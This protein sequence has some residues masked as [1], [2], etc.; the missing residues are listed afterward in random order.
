M[1]IGSTHVDPGVV[2]RQATCCRDTGCSPMNDA[3]DGDLVT[4][5]AR[6]LAL[7]LADDPGVRYAVERGDALRLVRRRPDGLVEVDYL[8]RRWVV[9]EASL[10]LLSRLLDNVSL[11]K[12]GPPATAPPAVVAGGSGAGP[13]APSGGALATKEQTPDRTDRRIGVRWRMMFVGAAVVALVVLTL[14]LARRFNAG[15]AS[16]PSAQTAPSND[17]VPTVTVTAT[18]VAPVVPVATPAATQRPTPRATVVP[19]VVSNL[20]V[21]DSTVDCGIA[22]G[23]F[24]RAEV[25][26]CL[27]VTPGGSGGPLVLVVT[28]GANPPAGAES[29]SVLARS[30]PVPQDPAFRCHPVRSTGD[31]L[32]SGRYWLWAL[33]GVTT[34]GQAQF[35]IGLP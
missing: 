32:A 24:S 22:E 23:E 33:D 12:D 20:V 13:S 6:T 3:R 14:L 10:Q 8:Q 28:S 4:P 35:V 5:R 18:P 17:G 15:E 27:R 19:P 25:L 16:L 31:D 7:Q 26:A 29:A 21:C 11:Q 2:D 1:M 9:A 30:D 34:V